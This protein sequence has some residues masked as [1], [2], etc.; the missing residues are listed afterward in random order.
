MRFRITLTAAA[1]LTATACVASAQAATD[2]PKVSFKNQIL[3]IIEDHCVSCHSPGG[4]GYISSSMDLRSY[5]DLRMGSIDGIAVIPFHADRSPLMRF[6][7]TNWH[8]KDKNAVKMPPLGPQLSPSDLNLIR[9]WINQG[10]KN[11]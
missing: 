1:L 5:K 11:N 9:T 8:S 10:A 4:I 2:A 7:D 6:L 3:P